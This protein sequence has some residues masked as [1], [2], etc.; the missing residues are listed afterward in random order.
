M[1]V[2]VPTCVCTCQHLVWGNSMAVG[3]PS[4][5]PRGLHSTSFSTCQAESEEPHLGQGWD[6]FSVSRKSLESVS[7]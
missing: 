7:R 6:D 5:A 1:C 3:A 4:L 2:C